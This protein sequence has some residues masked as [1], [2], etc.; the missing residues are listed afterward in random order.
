[1]CYIGPSSVTTST[2]L[3]IRPQGETPILKVNGLDVLYMIS[4]SA[5]QNIRYLAG[6][7]T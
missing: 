5:G 3:P 4:G 6:V 2:G 7:K 1:M